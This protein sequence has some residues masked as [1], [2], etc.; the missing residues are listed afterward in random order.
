MERKYNKTIQLEV[1]WKK[2]RANHTL[3][4][5]ESEENYFSFEGK[6]RAHTKQEGEMKFNLVPAHSRHD[7]EFPVK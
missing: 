4:E 2:E 1:S 3:A 6:K 7:E 5:T